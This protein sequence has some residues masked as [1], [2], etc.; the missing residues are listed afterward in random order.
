MWRIVHDDHPPLPDGISN[1][2]RDFLLLCFEKDPMHRIDAARLLRHRWIRSQ[3]QEEVYDI[4][5]SPN[6]ELPEEVHNTIRLHIDDKNED[7]KDA[8]TETNEENE[9]DGV[10]PPNNNLVNIV[11]QEGWSNQGLLKLK[12][13]NYN[14]N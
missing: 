6:N 8:I 11:N 2:C 3:D 13:L 4:I 12:G 5:N 9:Q 7:G 1:D 14:C 10:F